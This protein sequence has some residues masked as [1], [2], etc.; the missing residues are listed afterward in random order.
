MKWIHT[1]TI[2][3]DERRIKQIQEL[4]L[5]YE[6]NM[7]ISYVSGKVPNAPLWG[8][9]FDLLMIIQTNISIISITELNDC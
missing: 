9:F 8:G 3:I 6:N 5:N 1:I 2:Y 7:G 4:R